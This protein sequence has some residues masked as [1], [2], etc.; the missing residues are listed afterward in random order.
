[1]PPW[2]P[3]LDLKEL[4]E[5]GQVEEAFRRPTRDD[6]K[7]LPQSVTHLDQGMETRGV[8]ELQFGGVDDDPFPIGEA[9][10][11]VA[12]SVRRGQVQFAGQAKVPDSVIVRPLDAE[13]L[14][15]TTSMTLAWAESGV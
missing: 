8:D 5:T 7:A 14:H 2:H 11:G 15:S 10:Q 1:V 4:G 12:Q 3:L 13:P 9:V 6:G